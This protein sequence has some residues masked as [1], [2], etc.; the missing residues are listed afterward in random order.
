MQLNRTPPPAVARTALACAYPFNRQ[1]RTIVL[2]RNRVD[3][4]L[5][6]R[7][8]AA[9]TILGHILAHEIGHILLGTDV[10]ASAGLMKP[11][12]TNI[13]YRSH[14]GFEIGIF[15]IAFRDDPA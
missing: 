14:A 11:G 2:F 9:G 4:M 15:P 7:G 13:R 3:D 8:A 12:S 1:S 5:N 10:H 6:G